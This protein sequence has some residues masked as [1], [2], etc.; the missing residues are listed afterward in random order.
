MTK[1]NKKYKDRLFRMAFCEKKDLLELY[2]AKRF[3]V[4]RSGGI[5]DCYL[6]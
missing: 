5:G 3:L 1:I 4:Q 2:N 6:R